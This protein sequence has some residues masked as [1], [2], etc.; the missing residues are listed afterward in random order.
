MVWMCASKG[1]NITASPPSQASTSYSLAF[2][3]LFYL[4][5]RASGWP[6]ASVDGHYGPIYSSLPK[7]EFLVLPV[8]GGSLI[9]IFF[10]NY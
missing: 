7:S 2:C 5:W 4:F 9:L 3:V 10:L 8:A 1:Y 6:A